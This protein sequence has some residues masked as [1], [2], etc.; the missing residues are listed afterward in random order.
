MKKY[1]LSVTVI[2]LAVLMLSSCGASGSGDAAGHVYSHRGASGEETEH[3]FA[4]YDLAILYGSRYIEQ[5]I[6]ISGD[7]TLYVSHDLSALRLTGEDALYEEMTDSEID[8]LRT[9]DGQSVLRL[10]DVF[11]RYGR[12]VTYVIE[13]KGEGETTDAF[14]TIVRDYGFQDAIIVQSFHP[15][16]L[17]T[18]ESLFPDMPKLFLC[19]DQKDFDAALDAPYADILSVSKSLMNRGNADAAHE[20][21]KEFNVWTL[22][23]AA[24]IR[25]AI[26]LGVD[27]YFTN[28]TAKA[29]ALEA[30]YRTP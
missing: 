5:D 4:A 12:S 15:D 25:N 26:E 17:E 30:K 9:E 3:T 10:S 18:L 6:V 22:N 19:S 2:L 27:T 7:G 8:A 1:L 23:S 24:E 29:L 20:H 28:F 11:D 13:L 21:G 14:A 16:V